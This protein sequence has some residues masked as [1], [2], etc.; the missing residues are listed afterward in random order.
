MSES[1]KMTKGSTELNFIGKSREYQVPETPHFNSL[2]IKQDGKAPQINTQ[3]LSKRFFGE[4]KNTQCGGTIQ[5]NHNIKKKYP[6][7]VGTRNSEKHSPKKSIQERQFSRKM[8][9]NTLSQ[10]FLFK[11]LL[12]F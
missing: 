5:N 8:S 6:K 10:L 1:I 2:P 3:G 12:I 9:K 7:G 11:F 4:M